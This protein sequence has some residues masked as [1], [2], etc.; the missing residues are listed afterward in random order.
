MREGG[1]EGGGDQSPLWSGCF[2]NGA[3]DSERKRVNE[4]EAVVVDEHRVKF[5]TSSAG[6]RSGS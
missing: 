4:R 6:R 5:E 3:T 1:R 2:Y